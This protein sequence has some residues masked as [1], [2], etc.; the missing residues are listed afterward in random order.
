VKPEGGL[1]AH[2]DREDPRLVPAAMKRYSVASPA[3][4]R[5]KKLV[6]GL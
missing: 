1:I 4:P 3:I 5:V 6:G 2:P